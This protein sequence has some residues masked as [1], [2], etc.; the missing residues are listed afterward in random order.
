[1]ERSQTRRWT[2]LETVAERPSHK[3]LE[4]VG[5]LDVLPITGSGQAYPGHTGPV[6]PE[7]S[8]T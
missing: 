8:A 2:R 7:P 5:P 1:M 6:N 4:L 3:V